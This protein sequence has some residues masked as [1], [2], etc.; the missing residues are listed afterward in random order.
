MGVGTILNAKKII[1][2]AW[3]EGKSSIV[4]ETIEGEVSDHVPATFLQSHPNTRIVLDNA[5]SAN[6]VRQKTPWLVG[7]VNGILLWRKPP[8]FG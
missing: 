7:L 6:L 5:S 4:Q 3:G 1:L 8:L 2:M